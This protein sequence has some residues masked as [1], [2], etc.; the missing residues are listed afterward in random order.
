[1][2]HEILKRYRNK[3]QLNILLNTERAKSCQEAL[4][5]AITDDLKEAIQKQLDN[6]SGRLPWLRERLS[7]VDAALRF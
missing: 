6:W 2:M 4:A 1:M 7:E 3:L 5:R